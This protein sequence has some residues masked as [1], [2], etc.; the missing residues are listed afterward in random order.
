MNR[1][2]S[3]RDAL[4]LCSLW[5]LLA[6]F[7]V[8]YGSDESEHD[9]A[10]R[11]SLELE[12]CQLDLQTETFVR[13]MVEADEDRCH[14]DRLV[15]LRERDELH[16]TRYDRLYES[17]AGLECWQ[18]VSTLE[19]QLSDEK[20]FYYWRLKSCGA[21]A[22]KTAVAVR[23]YERKVDEMMTETELANLDDD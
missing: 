9:A 17:K 23:R 19:Q 15:S 12:A 11:T 18:R 20:N 4:I 14:E 21:I 13:A 16:A 6:F 7:A 22:D 8:T 1:S 5:I 3:W 2:A 10:A